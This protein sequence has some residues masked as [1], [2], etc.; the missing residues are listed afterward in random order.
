MSTKA[1][2]RSDYCGELSA[3]DVGRKVSL[4]GW[5][6]RTRNL[7][8]LIF[9][10]LRDKTGLVQ[11]VF[12]ATVCGND[13]FSVGE[14]LRG[15]YVVCA[16]GDVRLRDAAAVN[17]KL[18]TGQI[19]VFVSGCS[20][21]NQAATPPIY[22]DDD[23]PDESETVRL[24]YR[25]L[26]LRKPSV[27]NMLKT[28]SLLMQT[29]RSYMFTQRFTEVETPILTKSTPEGARDY[30]VPSRVHP[31][32][33]YALPQSPQIYKQL[34]MLGGTDRYFQLARCFRDEDSRADRQPEFTQCDMEMSF[35]TETDIQTVVE[36]AF[37][38]IFKAI[39]NADISL[40]LE[41][42]TWRDAMEQY[43]SD[44]PDRRFDLKLQNVSDWAR[45]CG[46]SVFEN[47]V[48]AGGS[49]RGINVKGKAKNLSRK[50]ID[51]LGEFVKTFKAKGLAWMTLSEQGVK[52]P[53]LKFLSEEK[54]A[55]LQ[56]RM[57]AEAGDALFFV[58]DKDAVVFQAL[59]Q[60]R[61][62]IARKL[63]LID[64]SRYD[65][66]WVTEFP[67][68]EWDDDE[69]RY[70][71]MHHPFTSPMDEDIPLMQS[72]PGKVRAKSYDLVMNGVEMGSGS[73]RIHD[74]EVQEKMFNMIGFSHEEAWN[75]FGFMLE[76]FK[77]GVPPHGGF[78][79]GV[80]RVMMILT[81]AQSLRD[82]L[83][84]PKA[85]NGSCLMMETPSAVQK[86][87][88]DLLGIEVKPQAKAE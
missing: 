64:K 87:Q 50:E 73:I 37:K 20:L 66:F 69:Q 35:V 7:G 67:L 15:E 75:R 8:G 25:Y 4:C 29:L 31:G 14:S 49:V 3:A 62:E 26:E 68:L 9:V 32:E 88:L 38:E 47:A 82:V 17:E 51:A 19:E 48:A 40:P 33:F 74:P 61:L 53:F 54:A 81:G 76:A 11:L 5:V 43:G 77:Y 36:G 18:K 70:V 23:H 63:D 71:A 52:S 30:L 6:Q 22:I 65:L 45:D 58:A 12:D 83:A 41:R 16:Q 56:K 42:I 80:D 39:K 1:F 10:W 57:G 79:F 21:L 28:R 78:A 46:F 24:K 27:Q 55:E 2:S 34:L 13:V 85:S 59:G 72:D 86:D 60:L 44:K 84:F